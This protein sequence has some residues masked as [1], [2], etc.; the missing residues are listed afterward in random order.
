MSRANS[1]C[2]KFYT[3]MPYSDENPDTGN[4]FRVRKL[5]PLVLLR[6]N[7]RDLA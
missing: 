2:I 1:I 7:R 3:A 4:P 6:G 5:L